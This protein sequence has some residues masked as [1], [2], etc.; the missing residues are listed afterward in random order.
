MMEGKKF[1]GFAR[2]SK[3]GDVIRLS[4]PIEVGDKK[5]EIQFYI[6]K[7]ELADLLERRREWVGV[8]P[9]KDYT[10]GG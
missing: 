8:R 10:F 3:N 2:L 5:E 1:D 9:F 7:S 6:V 4:F